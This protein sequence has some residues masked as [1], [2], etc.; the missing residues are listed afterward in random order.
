MFRLILLLPLLVSLIS[1]SQAQEERPNLILITIDT[2]RADRVGG[3]NSITPNIDSLAA[4]G[5][6][7]EQAMVQVPITLPSHVSIMT[8]TYPMYHGIRD[9]GG[10]KLKEERETLAELLKAQGYSTAAFVS[11]FALDSRWGLNQGFESYYDNFDLSEY[12]GVG[13]NAVERRA[14]KTIDAVLDWLENRPSGP[15]FLWVHLFDPHDPYE[16]PSPYHEKFRHRPYDGE[17]AYTDSEL[18]RLLKT[19][20]STDLYRG[21]MIVLMG[22]HGEGLGEHNEETHGFFVYN[23]TLQV[24]L[25]V[26]FS[27]NRYSG[28]RV[29]SVVQSVDVA[30]TILQALRM[31]RGREMQGN[32]LLGVISGRGRQGSDPAYSESY[33][34]RY[35]FGWSSLA[36][37]QDQRYKFIRAPRP[38]LYDLREDPGELKN[39]FN[40]LTALGRQYA[41]LLD[42]LNGKYRNREV[43]SEEIGDID[44]ETRQ[45]LQSL[46]YVAITSGKSGENDDR[47]R[48]D[49]KDKIGLFSQIRKAT[50]DTEEGR[51]ESSINRLQTVI[52]EDPD[53][54]T[55]QYLLGLNF[56]QTGQF[57]LA[58]DRFKEAIQVFPESRDAVHALAGSYLQLGMMDAARLGYERLLEM[59]PDSTR[60]FVGLGNAALK[61]RDAAKAEQYY[62]KALQS[63]NDPVARVGLSR[64]LVAQERLDEAIKQLK[65]VLSA[66]PGSGE[67]H[68]VLGYTYQQKGMETEARRHIEKA[69]LL[70]FKPQ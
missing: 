38:E 35:H 49:P 60:A 64:A 5:V 69:H 13:F 56:Y 20:R 55:A 6:V 68:F 9:F 66:F 12:K 26:K 44:D 61:S 30:P 8:A 17:V 14:D 59:E 40:E 31:P 45:R 27:G 39:L 48:A 7:F 1:E 15:F 65:N 33:Y 53:I 47:N 62:R 36:A 3:Q 25:I 37:Y 32:G 43:L 41:N 28:Q 22:D 70:G 21:S 46:G 19:L 51:I 23:T 42:D 11:S 57:A 10:F 18:G 54:Y 58:V 16:P 24:P 50:I 63:S 52:E 2:L 29:E 67:A 34:A 4:D